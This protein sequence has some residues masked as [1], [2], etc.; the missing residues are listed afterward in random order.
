MAMIEARDA[1]PPELRTRLR[2]MATLVR[3][4]ILLGALLLLGCT[5]WVWVVPGDAHSQVKEAAAVDIDQMALH[6]QVLGG[7]WTLLP[8]GIALLAL[9]RLWRL[10]GE[11]AQ[12]RVFS[13]RALLSLRGFA[14]CVLALAFASPIYG[15]ALSVI[16]TFD[17]KPGTRE[18][19]L[20]FT[21]GDYTMLLIGA[22]LLAIAGVMAEAARVAEDNA[23]F[24]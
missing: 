24:V 20:Q 3:A 19:N 8:V 23:G 6:T 15:A 13:Q 2:R 1:V 7:L 10:F 12:A 4:L 21:S 17:R 16:V 9:Q 18:L 22:V 14:R 11:Y 5:A